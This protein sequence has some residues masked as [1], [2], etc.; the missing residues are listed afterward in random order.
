MVS[1]RN[2]PQLSSPRVST[3]AAVTGFWNYVR[4]LAPRFVTRK[5]VVTESMKYFR[6]QPR[7]QQDPGEVAG[8]E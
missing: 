2:M 3:T 1:V 7:P 4:S 6:P 8:D 5:M